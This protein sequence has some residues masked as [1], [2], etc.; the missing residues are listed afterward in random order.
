LNGPQLELGACERVTLGLRRL[1]DP[2]GGMEQEALA[3][4]ARACPDCGTLLVVARE[5]ATG[6]GAARAA[7]DA[8]EPRSYVRDFSRLLERALDEHRRALADL[9]HEIGKAYVYETSAERL[10]IVT[11]RPPGDPGSLRERANRALAS[12]RSLAPIPLAWSVEGEI[13]HMPELPDP[14]VKV[15]AAGR[16]LEASLRLEPGNE[17]ALGWLAAQ[18]EASG[19][20]NEAR[21][22]FVRI[23]RES[24]PPTRSRALASIARFRCREHDYAAALAIATAASHL[25]PR[26]PGP[27]ANLA[28]YALYLGEPQLV[29][30]SLDVLTNLV[31]QTADRL[32]LLQLT[33][34]SPEPR[35]TNARGTNAS[36]F[37]SLY[38]EFPDVVYVA[39]PERLK[40][41]GDTFP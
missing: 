40:S 21:N 41:E 38:K 12:A 9:F 17:P 39:T 32:K 35:T 13:L 8:V 29:R 15:Y 34:L 37:L 30:T 23:A 20:L 28:L 7:I 5:V 2:G 16:F 6:V 27:V 36:W 10:K 14:H 19:E 3:A 22:L 25:G 24:S 31:P 18:R 33:I 1:L 26:E 4:H 11:L